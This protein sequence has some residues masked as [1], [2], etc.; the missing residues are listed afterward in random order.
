M[1][2]ISLSLSLFPSSPPNAKRFPCCA[3][4][5]FCNPNCPFCP[6]NVFG[7][8][9]DG[10][11]NNN[12]NDD[13]DDDDDEDD[14]DPDHTILYVSLSDDLFPT[15]MADA[16][17]LSSVHS[18][19][20]SRASKIFGIASTTTTTT[21]PTT[22]TEKPPDPT[23][24]ADCMFWDTLLFYTF[25]IYNIDNWAERDSGKA[26]HDEESGCGAIAHWDW[27]DETDDSY[28][29]VYFTLPFFMKAGCVERA[30][31]SAGGPK[32]SCKG[33]G[34]G[35]PIKRDIGDEEDEPVSVSPARA[36]ETRRKRKQLTTPVFPPFSDEVWQVCQSFYEALN[37]EV[38]IER[39]R[40]LETYVPMTWGEN[41]A[42]EPTTTGRL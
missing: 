38:G 17:A 39:V 33:G 18:D 9:G 20:M 6:P 23:P 27:N 32:L 40:E 2:P 19:V 26:L 41:S 31:V 36:L 25:E 28:A 42:P 5:D 16:A 1:V 30:I 13:D 11:G 3:G 7:P 35:P 14:D 12:D 21:K 10:G 24:T 15:A 37:E 4:L 8:P 22:T 34:I 29:Y